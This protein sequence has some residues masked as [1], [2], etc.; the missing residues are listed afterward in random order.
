MAYFLMVWFGFL[1]IL[2][3]F[4]ALEFQ[5]NQAMDQFEG[6]FLLMVLLILEF[7]AVLTWNGWV[8]QTKQR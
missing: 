8:G 3:V 6:K 1:L 2:A 4:T 7:A 5:F